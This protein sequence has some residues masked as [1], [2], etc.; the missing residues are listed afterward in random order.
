MTSMSSC[1][2]LSWPAFFLV[3]AARCYF[4]ACKE[5]DAHETLSRAKIDSGD[6]LQLRPGSSS[7]LALVSVHS[8]LLHFTSQASNQPGA[9]SS[10][11]ARATLSPRG[12]IHPHRGIDTPLSRPPPPFWHKLVSPVLYSSRPQWPAPPAYVV[13][14]T[15]IN[16]FAFGLPFSLRRNRKRP[17]GFFMG[18][19]ASCH[20]NQGIS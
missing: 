16:N 2:I 15:R 9:S 7:S 3:L 4:N 12:A 18:D 1:T 19:A 10:T 8:I 11:S 6:T 13:K 14:K 5:Q 17:V 20:G